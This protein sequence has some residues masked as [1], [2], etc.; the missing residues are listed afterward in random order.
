[1]NPYS[2]WHQNLATVLSRSINW[3]FQN[4]DQEVARKQLQDYFHK[5]KYGNADLSG[6]LDS[7][8]I[9][10]SLKISPIEQVQLL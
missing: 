4:N 2:E 6:N 9:E 1:M 8:W 10:S 5:I 3:Y 7:Y